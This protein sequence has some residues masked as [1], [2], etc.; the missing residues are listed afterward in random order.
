MEFEGKVVLVT[1]SAQ[2]I[3]KTAALAFAREGG[4]VVLNDVN[5]ER[6]NETAA[7]VE[8][9]GA[10]CLSIVANTAVQ[11]EVEGMFNQ[12]IEE[13]GHVD[14]L[15][16]NAGITRDSYLHKMTEEQ[17]KKVIDVNLTGVFYCLQA[18]AKIMRN[19]RR[20]RIINI[21]S[22]ARFGNMGQINYSASKAGVV[23]LTR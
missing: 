21:S 7:E 18:A 10:N 4:I 19:A 3:G 12:V 22:A 14:I 11:S 8:K 9:T 20:G 2:G 6:L 5:K 23:G 1:G 16:N 15:V 13:F 17:W